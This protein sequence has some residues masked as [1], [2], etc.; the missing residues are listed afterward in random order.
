[1]LFGGDGDDDVVSLA[2]FPVQDAVAAQEFRDFVEEHAGGGFGAFGDEVG[3]DEPE[4]AGRGVKGF[5]GGSVVSGVVGGE[6]APQTP[7]SWV[8]TR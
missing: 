2:G 8:R 3:R 4:E 7:S 6:D 1:M 5:D